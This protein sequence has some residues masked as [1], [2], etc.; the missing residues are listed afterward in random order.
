MKYINRI[1]WG[2]ALLMT[3]CLVACDTDQE[4]AIYQPQNAE[5]TF[6]SSSLDP[7]AVP[8][9][10]PEFKVE[11]FRGNAAATPSVQPSLKVTVPY[12]NSNVELS[13]CTISNYEFDE[14]ANIGYVTVNVTP[15]EIGVIATVTVTIGDSDLSVGG[16]QSTTVKVNKEYNWQSLGKGTYTDNW[17]WGITYNVEIMKAEGFERYRIMDPYGESIIND[18]GE[19]GDWLAPAACPYVEFATMDGGAIEFEP[20]YLGLYYQGDSSA[21]VYAY[22][23]WAFGTTDKSMWLD[24][25]TLQLAPYYYVPALGG[26]WNN[27]QNN[28]VII[29]T[30]P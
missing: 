16:I 10:A 22:P 1:I 18:D 5:L 26:G 9:N 23:G 28:G 3:G 7:V 13:G 17:G 19:W 21:K 30:L 24:S 2:L 6:S 27:T 14:N 25:K 11:V 8:A 12:N 29:V 15:L 20:F 4:G